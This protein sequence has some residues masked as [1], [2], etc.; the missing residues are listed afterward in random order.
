MKKTLVLIGGGHAHV[1]VLRRLALN[2]LPELE[3]ALFDPSPGVWYSGMVPGVIAGHYA[4]AE[5]KVNLW[6]LCQRARV[7]FIET[8][9]L[10]LDGET[11]RIQTGLGDRHRFDVASIDVGSTARPLPIAEGAYVVAVKPVEPLLNAI[12]ER[13]SLRSSAQIVRIIGGGASAVEIALGLAYRWREAPGR[14]ISL[15]SATA[16]LDEFP[17]RVRRLALAACRRWHV[18][19]HEN[20]PVERI[21]PTSLILANGESKDTQ[22]TVLATGYAPAALLTQTNLARTGDGSLMVNSTL[23]SSSHPTVFASGDC[24]SVGNYR[25][26]KSGVFAVRQGP[27][28][29]NNLMAALEERPLAAYKHDANALSLI[30][31]GDK[32]AIATRN[33]YTV[34]GGWVWR[35]KNSTDAKWMDKYRFKQ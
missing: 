35:W 27:V 14:K 25:L 22:L 24:A 34:A 33:G 8:S 32:R 15:I 12:V 19:V 16:L 5:A 7:R 18:I 9:V 4:P 17:D 20:T 26:P 28:L 30:S 1:E 3:V 10:S 31:L 2:P 6:A 13:E 21:E 29:F 23:Q 11:Q